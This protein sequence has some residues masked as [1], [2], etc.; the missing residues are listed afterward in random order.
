MFGLG[1]FKECYFQWLD[2]ELNNMTLGIH[3]Q[4][5]S[6]I[7]TTNGKKHIIN[8]LCIGIFFCRVVF[9]FIKE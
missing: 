3:G 8:Q 5:W 9:E 1:Q 6:C 4:E 7:P 2:P